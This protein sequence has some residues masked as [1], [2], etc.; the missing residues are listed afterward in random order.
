[1]AYLGH[2]KLILCFTDY[3]SEQVD[4]IGRE[5]KKKEKCESHSKSM[6]II[7]MK[8]AAILDRRH[9]VIDSAQV[10]EQDYVLVTTQL[11]PQD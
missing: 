3:S 4:S 2:T 9:V 6:N 10:G 5:K 1:M 11:R 7:K 8:A